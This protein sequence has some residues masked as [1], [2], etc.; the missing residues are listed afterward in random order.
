MNSRSISH[1]IRLFLIATALMAATSSTTVFAQAIPHAQTKARSVGRQV[2][3]STEPA[4]Q[5]CTLGF[6]TTAPFWVNNA[7]DSRPYTNF[8]QRP[9]GAIVNGYVPKGSIV[10]AVGAAPSLLT[11][12]NTYI[13]VRVLSVPDAQTAE[14]AR[15]SP[16]EMAAP[17]RGIQGTRVQANAT[18]FIRNADLQAA[19]SNVFVV[20][21]NSPLLQLGSETLDLQ[22]RSVRLQTNLI[23][24]YKVNRCCPN[25][26][27]GSVIDRV[28]NSV[29]QTMNMDPSCHDNYIFEVLSPDLKS[30]ERSFDMN[31]NQCTAFA[32]GLEVIDG[33]QMTALAGISRSLASDSNFGFEHVEVIP[34][35]DLL[36]I[37]NRPDPARPDCNTGPFG[38]C[39]YWLN[40]NGGASESARNTGAAE[41]N[42][43][44][45]S[46]DSYMHPVSACAFMRVLE[47]HNRTCRGPGCTIQ[48]GDAYSNAAWN[49]HESHGGK[50]CI[51][52]RPLRTDSSTGPITYGAG[53]YDRRKTAALIE[54]MK[55]AG[56][57]TRQIGFS[58]PE[59]VRTQGTQA[60]GGHDNHIHVCF[61]YATN[62][63]ATSAQVAATQ[64]TCQN[65]LG[66][67]P[68]PAPPGG[69]MS[70]IFSM[71]PHR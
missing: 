26:T 10:Q 66:A 29:A 12:P 27:S 65:G 67:S 35:A 16:Q 59:I 43:S 42:N 6:T 36:K 57:D 48:W 51:D 45:L 32:A 13:N 71:I 61:P 38:S 8:S 24:A 62:R 19:G 23:G 14:H 37:P 11:L 52:L 31:L 1:L 55:R 70:T 60:W 18:G 33:R 68:T 25:A 28:R 41:N 58:D 49:A 2:V 39:H 47:E 40:P 53:N 34:G 50:G 56:A 17:Y 5:T 22:G 15:R 3:P 20:K 44:E 9:D 30:V 64:R 69:V 4:N 21:Q 7:P 54:L 63:T 46:F